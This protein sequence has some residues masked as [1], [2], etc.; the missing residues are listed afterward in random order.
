MSIE[1]FFWRISNDS[2]NVYV[3]LLG[4]KSCHIDYIAERGLGFLLLSYIFTIHR[5]IM[6]RKALSDFVTHASYC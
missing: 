2:K 1:Y 3:C 5:L 4:E 6:T